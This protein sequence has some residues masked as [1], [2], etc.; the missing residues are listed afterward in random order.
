MRKFFSL[1]LILSG[2]MAVAQDSVGLRDSASVH[3]RVQ[4]GAFQN[5]SDL[6]F[7]NFKQVHRENEGGVYKYT[8]GF[9]EDLDG[10]VLYRDSIR[11]AG[12]PGAFVVGYLDGKRSS[13]KEI[14]RYRS[15]LVVAQR[16]TV[17]V[18][19]H[20]TLRVPDQ[21][22]EAVEKVA[23]RDSVTEEIDVELMRQKLNRIT[24]MKIAIGQTVL[25]GA[26][27]LGI[28]SGLWVPVMM[29]AAVVEFYLIIE[30]K[31]RFNRRDLRKITGY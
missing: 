27:A 29:G 19:Q 16:D 13:L 6:M 9:F 3:Y 31:Y 2:L 12:Y 7:D 5:P 26:I 8:V 11:V 23:H 4:V 14:E 1:V 24:W 25:G 20:D 10:A 18:T 17:Q 22:I 21:E 28:A 15:S 30:S